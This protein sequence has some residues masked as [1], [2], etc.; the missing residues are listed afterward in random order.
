MQTSHGGDDVIVGIKRAGT[1]KASQALQGASGGWRSGWSKTLLSGLQ[2]EQA[3]RRD[4]LQ[5]ET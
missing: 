5:N 4:F 2:W 1:P 3:Q